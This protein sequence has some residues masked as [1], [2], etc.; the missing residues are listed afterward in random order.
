[1]MPGMYPTPYQGGTP[2]FPHTGY[3]GFHAA[4]GFDSNMAP[5]PAGAG[6]FAAGYSTQAPQ[7]PPTVPA[8]IH[9]NSTPLPT[10]HR[11]RERIYYYDNE[12]KEVHIDDPD[13]PPERRARLDQFPRLPTPQANIPG[14]NLGLGY[15]I[16]ENSGHK[17]TIAPNTALNT[18][19]PQRRSRHLELTREGS[20]EFEVKLWRGGDHRCEKTVRVATSPGDDDVDIKL[21][22]CQICDNHDHEKDQLDKSERQRHHQGA[23]AKADEQKL[24]RKIHQEEYA[25]MRADQKLKLEIREE[26][27]REEELMRVRRLQ[28]EKMEAE[29][30][31]T[32]ALERERIRNEVKIE[33][34]KHNEVHNAKIEAEKQRMLQMEELI[35]EDAR[36]RE[37]MKDMEEARLAKV[38]EENKK[39][40]EEEAEQEARK[41]ECA[42]Q[43]ERDRIRWEVHAELVRREQAHLAEIEAKKRQMEENERLKEQARAEKF[44]MQMERERLANLAE[45]AAEEKRKAEELQKA[46]A[47]AHRLKINEE[48]R[49]KIEENNRRKAEED[50]IRREEWEK[51]RGEEIGRIRK[52]IMAE[53]NAAEAKRTQEERTKSEI[54]RLQQLETDRIR[55]D[56]QV[57][58]RV[59]AGREELKREIRLEMEKD[60]QARVSRLA[61]ETAVLKARIEAE[62]LAKE[63]ARMRDLA[64]AQRIR[65]Q[66]AHEEIIKKQ[67]REQAEAEMRRQ[68]QTQAIALEKEKAKMEAVRVKKQREDEAVR[69]ANMARMIAE[70]NEMRRI[71]RAEIKEDMRK[72][73]VW[74]DGKLVEQSELVNRVGGSNDNSGAPQALVSPPQRE[75]VQL[76]WETDFVEGYD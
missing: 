62:K 57:R 69:A 19:R 8:N 56:E 34:E 23:V 59:E 58:L 11:F 16:D 27:K 40:A 54:L 61:A 71:I 20:G 50:R 48:R 45:I 74:E 51:V 9:T 52:E 53:L 66:I 75:R 60:E 17:I 31:A 10:P 6:I 47:E 22:E 41:R 37:I 55:S 30:R 43:V 76:H 73:R 3:G 46:E 42:L 12:T 14:S 39:K 72:A 38:E 4:G 7:G 35:R 28:D 68:A 36:R 21:S 26:L 25:R 33:L 65:D 15:Y 49:A 29:R 70:E 2:G 5:Q 32:E 13:S 64:E 18:S 44:A 63:Q 67:Q 1:M 24:K